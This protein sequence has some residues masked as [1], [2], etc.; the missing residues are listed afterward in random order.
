MAQITDIVSEELVAQGA[1]ILSELNDLKRTT[2]SCSKELGWPH[3]QVE[4][5]SLIHI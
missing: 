3:N 4:D 1:L 2:A 5:L